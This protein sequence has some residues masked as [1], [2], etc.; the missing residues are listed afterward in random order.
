[1]FD[2][3]STPDAE[4]SI[5]TDL[6]QKRLDERRLADPWLAGYEYQSP[7]ALARGCQ[8]RMQKCQLLVATDQGRRGV[9]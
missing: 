8:P 7:L 2:A 5:G 6:S 4:R 1:L 9:G 3:L